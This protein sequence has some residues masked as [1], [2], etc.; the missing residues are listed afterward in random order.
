MALL[1]ETN[2]DWPDSDDDYN[3]L[4]DQEDSDAC[5]FCDKYNCI[6][7]EVYD[8]AQEQELLNELDIEK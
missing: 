4:M 2:G 3:K 5:F 8:F 6:C 1:Y 7:D